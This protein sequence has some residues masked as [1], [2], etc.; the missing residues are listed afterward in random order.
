MYTR[1]SQWGWWVIRL[2]VN[3]LAFLRL[4]VDLFSLWLTETLQIHFHCFKKLKN[5]FICSK[6]LKIILFTVKHI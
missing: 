6:K 3:I 5:N 4:T 1:G 2:T